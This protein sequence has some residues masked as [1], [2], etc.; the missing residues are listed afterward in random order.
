MKKAEVIRKHEVQLIEAGKQALA[1]RR[2]LAI[3]WLA[4]QEIIDAM[5]ALRAG[6]P[7]PN[8]TVEQSLEIK[9]LDP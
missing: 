5:R 2:Q 3:T 4:A 6:I 7:I 1:M 9:R 8:K